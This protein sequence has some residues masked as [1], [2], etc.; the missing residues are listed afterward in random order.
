MPAGPAG[1][2][3]LLSSIVLTAGKRSPAEASS[4]LYRKLGIVSSDSNSSD[5]GFGAKMCE[6]NSSALY[7]RLKF[8]VGISIL[9]EFF[10]SVKGN[11][12]DSVG[13]W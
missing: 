8:S 2:I 11:N 7:A 4:K 13:N 6:S 5:F 1:R 9:L 10:S 3:Y 12:E